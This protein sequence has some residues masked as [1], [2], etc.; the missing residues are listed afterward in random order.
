MYA[1]KV[2]KNLGIYKYM[3]ILPR[4]NIWMTDFFTFLQTLGVIQ[5]NYVHLYKGYWLK[6][7]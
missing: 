3:F 4:S 7:H 5:N 2:G 6:V 1:C